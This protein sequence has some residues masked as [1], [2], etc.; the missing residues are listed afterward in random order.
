LGRKDDLDLEQVVSTVT[1]ARA[2]AGPGSRPPGAGCQKR[3]ARGT[4]PF[5]S[6][7][8]SGSCHR[9]LYEKTATYTHY[10]IV[11]G[12]LL[13]SWHDSLLLVGFLAD[14]ELDLN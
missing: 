8:L 3:K 10:S 14:D 1:A 4:R 9:N 13:L 12:S 2:W 11:H 6:G 5:D 7:A